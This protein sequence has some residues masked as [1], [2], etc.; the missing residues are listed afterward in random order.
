MHSGGSPV[1]IQ[2][3]TNWLLLN[4]VRFLRFALQNKVQQDQK[5]S[6]RLKTNLNSADNNRSSSDLLNQISFNFNPTS[7]FIFKC[8]LVGM[9]LMNQPNQLEWDIKPTNYFF[10]CAIIITFI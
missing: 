9:S 5:N 8:V 10:L 1:S 3:I 2:Q 7:I 4:S 6:N